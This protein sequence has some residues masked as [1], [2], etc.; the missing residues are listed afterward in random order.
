MCVNNEKNS[1]K[2]ASDLVNESAHNENTV[3]VLDDTE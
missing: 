3:A 2:E 1:G